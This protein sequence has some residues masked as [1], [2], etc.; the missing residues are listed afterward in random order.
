MKLKSIKIFL[1]IIILVSTCNNYK[2]EK[3]GIKKTYN[4][5]LKEILYFDLNKNILDVKNTY[6]NGRYLKGSKKHKSLSV[7]W[8]D[9]NFTDVNYGGRIG[10][11]Q[12][13]ENIHETSNYFTTMLRITLNKIDSLDI[14]KQYENVC[15]F[16]RT[17]DDNIFYDS[18][19][20]SNETAFSIKNKNYDE[21]AYFYVKM[22]TTYS[23][24]II[25]YKSLVL[26]N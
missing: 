10:F 18:S 6:P 12:D 11:H 2:E 24:K 22:D 3:K 8:F 26:K 5:T 7:Y 23:N 9:A 25:I 16:V 20:Y 13:T 14:Q 1:I 19:S 15:D 4:V 17:I 21:I